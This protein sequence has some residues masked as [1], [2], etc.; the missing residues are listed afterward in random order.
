MCTH[1]HQC[2]DVC[3]QYL[4]CASHFSKNECGWFSTFAHSVWSK[5]LCAFPCLVCDPIGDKAKSQ[6]HP[7]NHTDE[8][9][10]S[11]G[12]DLDIL[13]T[14]FQ[15]GCRSLETCHQPGS[16]LGAD[17]HMSS[18]RFQFGCRSSHVINQ[19]PVWVVIFTCHQ[20][21][22]SLGGDL[23]MSSTRFQFG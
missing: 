7:L 5:S 10:S 18:T 16:S 9:V 20:P 13:S 3:L 12:A 2:I 1:E 8:P 21:G 22:S 4:C 15:F 6:L 23:H 19:V 14:R 17:L 11:L